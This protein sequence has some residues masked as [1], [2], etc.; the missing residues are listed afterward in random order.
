M[1]RHHLEGANRLNAHDLRGEFGSQL[2]DLGIPMKDISL[3]LGRS[4]SAATEAYLRPRVAQLDDAHERLLAQRAGKTLNF[5]KRFTGKT[6][7]S[8][9]DRMG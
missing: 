2:S 6:R 4:T 8:K 5:T 3:A 1:G 7:K 9:T